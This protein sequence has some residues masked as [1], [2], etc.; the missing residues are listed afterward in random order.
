MEPRTIDQL[1]IVKK[2]ANEIGF[3]SYIRSSGEYAYFEVALPS[4]TITVYYEIGVVSEG[5]ATVSVDWTSCDGGQ[6]S[7]AQ[8]N[9]FIKFLGYAVQIAEKLKE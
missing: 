9:D 5:Q 3:N 2:F 7:V 6:T 1:N 4:A 8:T